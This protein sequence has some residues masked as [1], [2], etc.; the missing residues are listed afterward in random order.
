MSTLEAMIS[1]AICLGV[2]RWPVL[3][4]ESEWEVGMKNQMV[5]AVSFKAVIM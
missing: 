5:L 2:S 3:H 4:R 1:S